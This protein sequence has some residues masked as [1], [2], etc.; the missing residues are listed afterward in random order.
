MTLLLTGITEDEVVGNTDSGILAFTGGFVH[1]GDMLMP[2][3]HHAENFRR[4]GLGAE[5]DV[6]HAALGQIFTC[7]SGM[8][9]NRSVEA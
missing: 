3:I 2:L 9:H 6:A 5:P 4:A 1:V 8:R 7:S